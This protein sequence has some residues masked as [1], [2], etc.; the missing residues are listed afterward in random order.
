MKQ[1]FI[2]FFMLCTLSAHAATTSKPEAASEDIGNTQG[3]SDKNPTNVEANT[4][5]FIPS[6]MI[7]L[8]GLSTELLLHT[9]IKAES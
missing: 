9:L 3:G 7:K 8:Y 2:T 1:I 5:L 6:K 4:I